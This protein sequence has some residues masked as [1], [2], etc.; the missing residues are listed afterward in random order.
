MFGFFSTYAYNIYMYRRIVLVSVVFIFIVVSSLV[1]AGG[2]NSGS[3]KQTNQEVSYEANDNSTKTNQQNTVQNYP[4]FLYKPLNKDATPQKAGF[5][6][7][8]QRPV[9]NDET[10]GQ[11]VYDIEFTDNEIFGKK[12]D[13]D[14]YDKP[15]VA[16]EKVE[17]I[18]KSHLMKKETAQEHKAEVSLGYKLSSFSEIY[19]GKGFLVDRKDN[20]ALQPHDDGWRIRFKTSF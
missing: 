19:L 1:Y 15:Y 7:L 16:F 18:D 9:N 5:I 11:P 12:V 3:V 6:R 4:G 8:K 13:N 2:P 10:N 20:S 17:N 14:S